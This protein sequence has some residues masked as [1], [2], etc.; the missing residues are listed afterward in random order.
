[1]APVSSSPATSLFPLA[2]IHVRIHV[3]VIFPAPPHVNLPVFVPPG[4]LKLLL[5]WI[6][7]ILVIS[8]SL[9]L[10]MQDNL[11]NYDKRVVA[12][13]APPSLPLCAL[14]PYLLCPPRVPLLDTSAS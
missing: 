5:P 8:G 2:C 6:P 14:P 9:V 3:L 7:E 4:F 11:R 10:Q 12:V 1:M 13:V